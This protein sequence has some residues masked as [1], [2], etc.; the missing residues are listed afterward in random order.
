[1]K[2]HNLH[3][4]A[5][6]L[7]ALAFNAQA[8]SFS[9]LEMG[10][11]IDDAGAREAALGGTGATIAEGAAAITA[12]PAG[13]ADLEGLQILFF[14]A[15][16][17]DD[18]RRSYPVHD[19]FSGYL[20]DNIY[21]L[22]ADR[23]AYQGLAAAWGP[24]GL[25]PS[26]GVAWRP[27]FAA[28]YSYRE[29]VLSPWRFRTFFP[30]EIR[31]DL[32]GQNVVTDYTD[33]P[34]GTNSYV[35]EGGVDQLSFGLGH[36][37]VKAEQWQLSLGLGMQYLM[38]EVSAT[39]ATTYTPVTVVNQIDGEIVWDQP[40]LP[41]DDQETVTDVD[42]SGDAYFAGLRL[43]VQDRVEF[44]YGFRSKIKMDYD[45]RTVGA[46]GDTAYT[47]AP[48][49]PSLHRFGV[50]LFPVNRVR[51]TIALQVDY[52]PWESEGELASGAAAEDSQTYR[53]GVEHILPGGTPFRFGF[54]YGAPYS[55]AAKNRV[56][57]TGGTR[58]SA[59][60]A[61]IDLAGALTYAAYRTPDL[62]D[63]SL[64]A[65]ASR[66]GLDTVEERVFRITA[67][68]IWGF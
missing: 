38:G 62:F 41:Y 21:A 36:D 25:W 3:T 34:L 48:T 56:G 31:S 45:V 51:T 44:S 67:T 42:G 65:A 9:E 16:Q 68:L 66:S 10:T 6:A 52:E 55:G 32:P 39:T 12:N 46:Q 5:L 40:L 22:N 7:C 61:H 63:D 49:Y 37:L 54:N 27:A 1:M 47:A 17:N 14:G 23:T 4:A 57:F 13:L 58:M 19:S 28:D 11:P 2:Q 8:I 64:F 59:G 18:E 20:T 29:H 60:P 24:G 15:L 50:Q 33:M 43:R 53:V 30:E 26:F 35:Q